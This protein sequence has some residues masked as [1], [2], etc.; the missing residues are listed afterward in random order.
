MITP[1][2]IS[3]A[4]NWVEKH[5]MIG[6]ALL[7]SLAYTA[8]GI[9]QAFLKRLSKESPHVDPT[10]WSFGKRYRISAVQRYLPAENPSGYVQEQHS[11]P[12][13][14]QKLIEIKSSFMNCRH[15]IVPKDATQI[16][17]IIISRDGKENEKIISFNR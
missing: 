17:T 5:P 3:Q 4:I 16:L 9:I 14:W 2:E 11:R 6:A 10:F 7:S 13:Q 12:D 8:K 1:E 15:K